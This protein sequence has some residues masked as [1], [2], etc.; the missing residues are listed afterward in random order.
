MAAIAP[1][2]QFVPADFDPSQWPAAEPLYLRLLERDPASAEELERWLADFAELFSACDEFSNRRYIDYTCHTDDPAIKQ[3]YLQFVE[4]IEPRAK[5]LVFELRRKFLASPFLPQLKT[6]DRKFAMLAKMWAADVEIYS[7]QSVPLQTQATKLI[8]RFS[9]IQGEMTVHLDGQEL[10]LPQA[11]Q[12]LEDNDRNKRQAAWE[13]ING[14]RYQD[15]EMVESIF[16]ELLDLRQRLSANAGLADYRGYI[17]KEYKRFDYS[18]EQ[19]MAFADAIEK[20]CVPLVDELN[21]RQQEELGLPVLRPWDLDVDAKGRPALTPFGRDDVDTLVHKTRTIFDRLSPA[22]GEDFHSLETNHNLDL[23]SRKGKAPGG[24][25][26]SLEESGQP[27]IFMNA[28]G[29]QN[30][31]DTLLHEGGHAFHMLAARNQLVFVRNAPIEFCEVASMSMELLGADHMEI[32]YDNPEDANRARRKQL[33]KT[34]R[35]LPWIATIDSFQHWLYANPGHTR[36]ERRK[37]WLGLLD[38][39]AAK[40][41]WSGYEHFRANGWQRQHHLFGSPLYYVEYGIAQLGALQM[42]VKS[43]HDTRRAIANYRAALKLGGTRPLPELFAA[44]GIV[45]DFSERTLGPLMEAVGE[46]LERLGR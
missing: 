13:A 9:D 17:W 21:R 15:R 28:V 6:K 31:V 30:D 37:H 18:A 38:R 42:W 45:F 27:F 43:R 35:V 24:Y 36:D 2:R 1:L 14:R 34:V 4:E 8:T 10:T 29:M 20:T 25:Q 22:L 5:P 26:T 44:A 12:F 19:C 3:R 32:F 39:F 16:D 11:N 41:D 46:E 23:A 40:V 7:D 33:E